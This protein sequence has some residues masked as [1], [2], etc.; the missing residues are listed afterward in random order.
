MDDVLKLANQFAKLAQSTDDNDL[1]QFLSYMSEVKRLTDQAYEA[2]QEG[3]DIT[4]IVREMAPMANSLANF[5]AK[6]DEK[7]SIHERKE[8]WSGFGSGLA[9][10]RGGMGG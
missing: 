4:D 5:A 10:T 1:E 7:E 9:G 6:I 3:Q 2:L 8:M